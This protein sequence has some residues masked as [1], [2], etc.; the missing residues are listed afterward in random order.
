MSRK[1]LNILVLIIS[2]ISVSSIYYSNIFGKDIINF[3]KID[4][5]LSFIC[6]SILFPLVFFGFREIIIVEKFSKEEDFSKKIKK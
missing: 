6:L 1:L 3:L 2:L 5:L 4:S